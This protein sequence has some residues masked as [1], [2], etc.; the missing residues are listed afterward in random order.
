MF[1]MKTLV[2][3]LVLSSHFA[4]AK[5]LNSVAELRRHDVKRTWDE[6]TSTDTPLIIYL[7]GKSGLHLTI[8]K[9]GQKL[10]LGDV[11]VCL[12]G[13]RP[14]VTFTN[15]KALEDA[16]MFI[17]AGLPRSATA[18]INNNHITI[19]SSLWSGTFVGR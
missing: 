8:S 3:L 12:E 18:Y 16:P 9:N 17:K 7:E 15:I 11:T 5:C 19:G 14:K 13:G 1:R 2:L 10:A 6:T 4:A